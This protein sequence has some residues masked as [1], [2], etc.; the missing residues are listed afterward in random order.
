MSKLVKKIENLEDYYIY[1]RRGKKKEIKKIN[2]QKRKKIREGV[3]LSIEQKKEVDN[4]YLKFY[5][6]KIPYM[7]HEHFFAITG[8]FDKKYFP[9]LL[10]IPEYEWAFNS[11]LYSTC[12]EDKNITPLIANGIEKLVSPKVLISCASGVY[13]DDKYKIISSKKVNEIV[14]DCGK[15]FIKPSIETGSGTGC[16]I[17]NFKNGIDTISHNT[18]ESVL[19]TYG[20]NFIIQEC[21][22]THPFIKNLHPESV[23]TFRVITYRMPN[24]KIYHTPTVI[25]IGV[26]KSHLDNA[27]AGG[28]FVGITDEGYLLEKAV[29]EFNESYVKHPDT[30]IVFK[31]YYIPQIKLVHEK[32][33]EFHGRI[34][35]IAI[36]NLDLTID[37]N[38]NIVLIEANTRGGG[39]WLPQMAW[40]KGCFEENTDEILSLLKEKRKQYPFN[41]K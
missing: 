11:K 6:K 8:K 20:G 28:I 19:N 21:I 41:F 25:R 3:K 5:G 9:E 16:N 14:R 37:E 35:Q 33:I 10:Y 4:Y 24:G 40:G 2:M 22:K 17:V 15:V 38:E 32:A 31:N 12:I 39:I 29:T 13:R 30:N 26:G 23:N 34:P 18:M 27:H 1:N 7:W 36:L